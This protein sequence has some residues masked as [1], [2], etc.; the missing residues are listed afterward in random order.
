MYFWCV[1][2]KRKN[3]VGKLSWHFDL[4]NLKRKHEET[5]EQ[6]S[7]IEQTKKNLLKIRNGS[8][9]IWKIKKKFK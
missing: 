3:R 7:T 5:K 6:I 8:Y 2:Q 9:F 4:S 1:W